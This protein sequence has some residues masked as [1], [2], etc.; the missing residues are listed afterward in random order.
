MSVFGLLAMVLSGGAAAAAWTLT[1]PGACH[2]LGTAAAATQGGARRLRGCVFH[3][4][5]AK[6]LPGCRPQ[7]LGVRGEV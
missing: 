7:G 5:L 4:F 6:S 1:A 2:R 3:A